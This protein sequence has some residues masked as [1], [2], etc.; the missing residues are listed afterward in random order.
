MVRVAVAFML[1]LM[2][3]LAAGFLRAPPKLHT[4][5]GAGISACLPAL[6]AERLSGTSC[7]LSRRGLLGVSAALGEGSAEISSMLR[8]GYVS[9]AALVDAASGA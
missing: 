4:Q 1:H 6:D 7:S 5:L 3:D 9:S 8:S 2:V